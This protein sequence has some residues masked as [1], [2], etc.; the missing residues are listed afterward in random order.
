ML[1]GVPPPPPPSAAFGAVSAAKPAA[2][3]ANGTAAKCRARLRPPS[4]VV[5]R[6]LVQGPKA[7]AIP[8]TSGQE[9]GCEWLGGRLER[10]LS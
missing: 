1:A 10:K 7:Y 4:L 3:S 6:G 5:R 8:S 2:S 9:A